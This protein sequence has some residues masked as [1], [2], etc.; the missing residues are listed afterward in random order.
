MS[1]WKGNSA[2]TQR[3]AQACAARQIIEEKSKRNIKR[4][5]KSY[6]ITS[7]DGETSEKITFFG[8]RGFDRG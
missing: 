8:K 5:R 7:R 4:N 3:E 1:I 6:A 2:P